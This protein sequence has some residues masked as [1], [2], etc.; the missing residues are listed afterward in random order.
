MDLNKVIQ[1]ARSLLVSPRT[2]WPVIAAERATVVDLYRDYIMIVAA[3]P[4][5]CQFVKTSILGY[6]WHGFRVYRLGI[7]QGLTAAI[8]EYIV[9]LI[10]VYVVAV[11]IEAL[12]PTFAGQPDRV[13]AL[14]VAGYSYTASWVAGFAQILP[15][16]YALF[17]LAGAIYSLFLL[18]L[19]LPGTMKVLPERAGSYAAVTA[20]IALATGWIIALITGAITGVSLSDSW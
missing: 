5:I 19:G 2:E 12:A 9:S 17:A 3:I 10:A 18:Y 14:K 8:V 16:L 7:G 1:R 11:V 6:A 4:P 20:I 15:G 13:Q